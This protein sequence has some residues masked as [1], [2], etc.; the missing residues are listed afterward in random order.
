MNSI[1]LQTTFSPLEEGRE[2][3]LQLHLT[4]SVDALETE[5]ISMGSPKSNPRAEMEDLSRSTMGS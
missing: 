5:S 4:A 1:D 2:A 3:W